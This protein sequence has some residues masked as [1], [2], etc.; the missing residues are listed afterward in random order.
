MGLQSPTQLIFNRP[1]RDGLTAHRR[2]FAPEWQREAREIEQ[3]QRK[4]LEKTTNYY[5]RDAKDLP[6]LTIGD[7]VLIQHPDSKRLT[8]PGVVVETGPNRD[9]MVKTPSG[10][11]FRRNRRM[12]R[13]RTVVMPGTIPPA[14]NEPVAVVEPIRP[15]PTIERAAPTTTQPEKRTDGQPSQQVGV[16]RG[17]G[18]G[19]IPPIRQSTRISVPSNRYPAEEWTK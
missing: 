7:H 16:G 4:M 10:R 15:I 14:E 2:S 1:I 8:T 11:I 13:K 6:E 12:L 17:R 5:N 19:R 3:R 9:Y 18:R